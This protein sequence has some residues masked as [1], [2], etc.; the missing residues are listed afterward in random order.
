MKRLITMAFAAALLTSSGF[1][2]DFGQGRGPN[3]DAPRTGDGAKNQKGQ[4][5]KQ[6]GQAKSGK[7]TGPQDGSGP[8]HTPG[9]GGGN[10]GGQRR[11]GGGRR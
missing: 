8:I 6:Q 1:A 10:G 2:L 5:G 9:T 11:G 7:R 3:P 4:K